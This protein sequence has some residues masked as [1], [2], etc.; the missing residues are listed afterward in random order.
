MLTKWKQSRTSFEIATHGSN[1]A[2]KTKRAKNSSPTSSDDIAVSFVQPLA[3]HNPFYLERVKTSK[4][5]K[6]R[7]KSILGD[8]ANVRDMEPILCI[9]SSHRVALLGRSSFASGAT[10]SESKSN[11][12]VSRPG[13]STSFDVTSNPNSN[14]K[15]LIPCGAQYDPVSNLMYAIRNG[16]ELAVWTA[17]SSS[18]IQGPDQSVESEDAIMPEASNQKSKKRK[19]RETIGTSFDKIICERL[20]FPEGMVPVTFNPFHVQHQQTLLAVGAS[21]CCQDGSVWVAICRESK[22]FELSI[23]GSTDATA[24]RKTGKRKSKP[25]ESQESGADAAN[26]WKVLDSK[27]NRSVI[28][29]NDKHDDSFVVTVRSALLSKDSGCL[30]LREHQIRV[31]KDGGKE[32]CQVE[33]SVKENILQV[34]NV[35]EVTARFDSS[36]KSFYI[37]HKSDTGAWTLSSIAIFPSKE[38]SPSSEEMTGTLSS[39]TLAPESKKNTT[40][41]SFGY[42]GQNMYALLAKEDVGDT[43]DSLISTL[44]IIDTRR[45]VEL[46]RHSWKEGYPDGVDLSS[47]DN[48][49]TKMLHDKQCL[50]MITNELDGTL[51]LV[52]STNN[53]EIGV[54]SSLLSNDTD[55]GMLLT[56]EPSTNASSLATALRAV[57]ALQSSK[58]EQP[59][60]DGGVDKKNQVDAAIKSACKELSEA[61]ESILASIKDFAS[62]KNE[63]LVNGKSKKKKGTSKNPIK[64]KNWR[65]EF[66][67]GMAAISGAQ[68]HGT[69]PKRLKNGVKKTGLTTVGGQPKQYISLAFRH[70]ISLL[71]SIHKRAKSSSVEENLVLERLREEAI[72]VLSRVLRSKSL[73]SRAE[74]DIDL[75]FGGNAFVHLFKSCP[76]VMLQ[77]D[78]PSSNDEEKWRSI[79]ALDIFSDM[80][81]YI[82]DLHERLTVCMIRFLLRNVALRDVASYYSKQGSSKM[83]KSP[84]GLQLAKQLIELPNNAVDKS[85]IETQLIAEAVLEFTAKLIKYSACNLSLLG[86]AFRDILTAAD[87]ETLLVIL[88]KLLKF[89]E[90]TMAK[91]ERSIHA[92]FR[93]RVIEW[94]SSLTDTHTSNILKMSDEGSL[95]LSRIQADV[96]SL[97]K[98]TQVANELVELYEH[99]TKRQESFKKGSFAKAE[100][101]KEPTYIA[102]YTVERLAF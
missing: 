64:L 14:L 77:S 66:D 81:N 7:R 72:F 97:V 36:G 15:G 18:V 8:S 48:V 60:F 4:S 71:I 16:S 92:R 93:I 6:K 89:G 25:S 12:Y 33:K 86:N 90:R 31:A 76:S 85:Q 43:S 2:A 79:G 88:S 30:I 32:S 17:S 21:G 69:S 45:K 3:R 40:L 23:V 59:V 38:L 58:P 39:V 70:T 78:E 28:I 95:A 94:I 41:F 34:A 100:K 55:V 82:D 74:Y 29:E 47:T 84:R 96:L 44:R 67:N 62:D 61:A 37:V 11:N 24:R 56:N 5:G 20:T 91:G 102:A 42:L 35:E 22:S 75:P 99:F 46:L 98:E 1:G 83:K 63:S 68:M 27:A 80:I 52:T 51:A 101:P 49:L 53:G 57:A 19:E 87:V 73:Q 65:D 13:P 26:E 9:T 10:L 54:I 50:A